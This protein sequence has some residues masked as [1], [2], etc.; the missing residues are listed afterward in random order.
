LAQQRFAEQFAA[1]D[2]D[3]A[4]RGRKREYRRSVITAPPEFE[5]TVFEATIVKLQSNTNGEWIVTLKVPGS[6]R[7]AA[8][9]LGDAYGLALDVVIV[10]KRFTPEG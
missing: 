10:R 7:S 3:P 9:V 5:E 2:A 8:T 4:D 1:T 6:D